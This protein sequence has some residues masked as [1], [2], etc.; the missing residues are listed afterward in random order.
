MS[1]PSNAFVGA[2]WIAQKNTRD[3][4]GPADPARR[5]QPWRVPTSTCATC[6]DDEY[7]IIITRVVFPCNGCH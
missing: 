7:A 2:S 1:N 3:A 4:I 5:R 6:T